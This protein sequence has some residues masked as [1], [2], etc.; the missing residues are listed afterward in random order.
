MAYA[1][2]WLIGSIA[3]MPTQAIT[4]DGIPLAPGGNGN[5][6]LWDAVDS[7][8]LV[9]LMEDMMDTAGVPNTNVYI[10][11]SGY[12]FL[13]AS[14]NFTVSWGV[15]TVMR[16]L[17]GFDAN[18]SGASSYVAPLKSPLLFMAGKPESPI[19]H[20]LATI[21]HKVNTVYQ[22]VS[23][24]SGKAE[25]VS[26]GS[27]I[28]ARY[29]FPMVDSDRVVASGNPGGTY[30]RFFDEVAVKSAR[31]KLY[32]DVTEDASSVAAAN[33]TLDEPLGPYLFSN[34]R[35][36]PTWSFDTSKGFERVDARC[37]IDV[38]AHV[39]EEYT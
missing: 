30:A 37:D 39:V 25:S 10:R 27:R 33:S 19:G 29:S 16:D 38:R 24:Y 12:V 32:R 3:G 31:F 26:H 6:Y 13:G 1:S 15:S 21:G 5:A 35:N 28:Y 2:A 17:L 11:Q 4:I 22:A 20:R 18:L 34:Q 23:A 8:N 14:A 7:R 9:K 36:A